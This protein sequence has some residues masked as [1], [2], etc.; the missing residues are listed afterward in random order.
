MDM[1]MYI[2][3]YECIE[4]LLFKELHIEKWA[5]LVGAVLVL[6]VFAIILELLKTLSLYIQS[7]ATANPLL[8]GN[9]N[10]SVNDTAALLVPLRIPPTVEHIK[11]RRLKLHVGNSMVYLLDIIIGYFLMLSVMTYNGYLLLAVVLGSGVGYFLFGVQRE[12]LISK[13]SVPLT[14]HEEEV[15]ESQRSTQ[16]LSSTAHGFGPVDV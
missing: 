7:K 13:K 5:H 4:H 2:R 15:T 10:N 3:F 1:K 6:F 11:K 9:E 12:K 8:E 16:P 14:N